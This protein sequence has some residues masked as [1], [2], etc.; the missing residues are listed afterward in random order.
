M[1][2]SRHLE[3][4]HSP[5][6]ARNHFPIMIALTAVFL[7]PAFTVSAMG[8]GQSRVMDLSEYK[9]RISELHDGV[10]W[11]LSY[12]LESLSGMSGDDYY[13][14]EEL[15]TVFQNAHD[16]FTNA[17]QAID[18]LEP[19]EEIR[20]L[21]LS[22][23]HFYADGR[24]E[25]G[26]VVNS[27]GLFQIILPMLLD[28]QNLAL[29]NL[30]D[31]SQLPEVKAAAEE[32]NRTMDMYLRELEGLTPPDELRGYLEELKALFRKVEGMVTGVEQAPPPGDVEALARFRQQYA[33]VMEEAG[34][35]Q[36][37]VGGYLESIGKRID[38][39]IER[40]K[41]LAGKIQKL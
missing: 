35:L 37:E 26:T 17:Y 41:E 22:L 3:R 8:C 25:T 15:K 13:H 28:M 34:S 9:K 4:M 5:S 12:V 10:A 39:L 30:P 33:S 24:E 20:D 40:G 38:E 29:P 27:L 1:I 7:I 6:Q 31:Q 23:M 36:E 16:I 14:L 21:H 11:D 18:S 2:A 19:P 32:D